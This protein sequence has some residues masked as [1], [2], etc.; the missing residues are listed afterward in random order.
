[1][2]RDHWFRLSVAVYYLLLGVWLGALVGFVI[3]AIQVFDTVRD[4]S[5]T[6]N[7]LP[8]SAEALTQRAPDILA[9]GIVGQVLGALAVLEIICAVGLVALAI[10]QCTIFRGRLRGGVRGKAN[11]GRLGLLAVA[12]LALAL[13]LGWIA[14]RIKELRRTMYN[15]QTTQAERDQARHRFEFHHTASERVMGTATLALAGAMVLSP[16]GLGTG[17]VTQE[18]AHD[19]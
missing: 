12:I 1:M 10:V 8:D 15:P 2:H 5:P 6:L 14:P 11:L 3:T 16:F 19:G 17:S 9:G 4:Y 7:Q 13:H 18:T